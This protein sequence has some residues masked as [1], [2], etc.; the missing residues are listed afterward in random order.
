MRGDVL[1]AKIIRARPEL[2]RQTLMGTSLTIGS[3]V[4]SGIPQ[5]RWQVSKGKN[6][7]SYGQGSADPYRYL[8]SCE[9][10]KHTAGVIMFVGD[11]A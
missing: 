10:R 8:V 7:R 9:D 2:G 5:P 4:R 6:S 3:A 1:K 11:M